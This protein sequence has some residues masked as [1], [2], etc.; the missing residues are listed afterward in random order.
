MTQAITA[1]YTSRN[2]AER[3]VEELAKLGFSRDDISLFMSGPAREIHIGGAPP[4]PDRN[5]A[6]ANFAIGGMLGAVLG[7][8][9]A[10][11]SLSIPGG[12]FVAGP[13]GA[14]VTGAAAGGAGGGVFG[15]LVGAGIREEEAAVYQ[16]EIGRDRILVRVTALDH[17]LAARVR[18][19]F[20]ATEGRVLTPTPSSS[21]SVRSNNV[22]LH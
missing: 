17:G 2:A 11:A 4:W 21:P 15:V 20:E 10:V 12:L 6:T 19:I 18:S 13:V 3:G 22:R 1:A 14:A 7:S 16:Q 9:A 5:E 8:L